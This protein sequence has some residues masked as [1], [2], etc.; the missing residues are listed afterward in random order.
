MKRHLAGGTAFA[1]RRATIHKPARVAM[2]T[3]S[4]MKG[5]PGVAVPVVSRAPLE[6]RVKLLVWVERERRQQLL[7][8]T[9]AAFQKLVDQ[10]HHRWLLELEQYDR[11]CR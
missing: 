2:P 4:V 6:D 5:G 9:T 7:H 11:E 10:H 1:V 3:S 8:Q